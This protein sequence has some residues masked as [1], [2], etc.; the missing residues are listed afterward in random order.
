MSRIVVHNRFMS[1]V[2]RLNI[3]WPLRLH[4]CE[5]VCLSCSGCFN[6]DTLAP[7]PSGARRHPAENLNRV[8][9]FLA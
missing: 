8:A 4:S 2:P 5:A 9:S 6:R 7:P 1:I 3:T